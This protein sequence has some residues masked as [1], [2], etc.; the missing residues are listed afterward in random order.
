MPKFDTILNFAAVIAVGY[1][2]HIA[3][4][5]SA[6]AISLMFVLSYLQEISLAIKAN[7]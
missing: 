6:S 2:V 5:T 1:S 3:D 4:Y 7:V